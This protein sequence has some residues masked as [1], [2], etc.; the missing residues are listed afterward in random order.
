VGFDRVELNPGE[1]RTVKIRIEP[2]QLSYWSSDDDRWT[3]AAG[4]RA[5]YVGASSRD[6]KL[7]GGIDVRPRT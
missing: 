3:V 5:I 1:S 6:I 2:R 7:T 4:R